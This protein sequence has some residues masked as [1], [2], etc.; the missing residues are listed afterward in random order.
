M[1]SFARPATFT[2]L[3]TA[4]VVVAAPFVLEFHFSGDDYELIRAAVISSFPIDADFRIVKGGAYFRPLSTLS[5]ALNGWISPGQPWSYHLFNLLVHA[6]NA[7]LAGM[8]L[9]QLYKTR[10]RIALLTGFVFFLLPQGVINAYWIVGRTDLLYTTGVLGAAVSSL[11][12]IRYGMLRYVVLMAVSFVAALLSKESGV[13]FPLYLAAISALLLLRGVDNPQRRRMMAA[14]AFSL[15]LVAVYF[16]HR[17]SIFGS[18]LGA[19]DAVGIHDSGRAMMWLLH[20]TAS[21]V[22]PV[23]PVD[24]QA[25]WFTWWPG[26]VLL[27]VLIAAYLFAIATLFLRSD[28]TVRQDVLVLWGAGLAA[29]LLYL[30]NFPSMRLAYGIL[31]LLLLPAVHLLD[32]HRRALRLRSLL[33]TGTLSIILL[34]NAALIWKFHH[35]GSWN[36]QVERLTASLPEKGTVYVVAQF[37]RIGQTISETAM[38]VWHP[39]IPDT[40][41]GDTR[42]DREVRVL[43]RF[44]GSVFTDWRQPYTMRVKG[45]TLELLSSDEVSGFVPVFAQKFSSLD[46]VA[47]NGFILRPVEFAPKRAGVLR[48]LQAFHMTGDTTPVIFYDNGVFQLTSVAKLREQ[49]SIP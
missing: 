43:G 26:A 11:L 35:I 42:A 41:D 7:V 48:R 17:A 4:L 45:D 16:A 6:L 44:E 34:S 8:L 28:R 27:P 32:T 23:D 47:M 38:P 29:L 31:P 49:Y 39:L 13:L 33:L 10:R 12:F 19:N 2:L 40:D 37:G 9:R 14:F 25:L 30:P 18:V 15:I 36:R 24:Y 1:S 21:L 20:G 5:F 46:D 3:L 22:A